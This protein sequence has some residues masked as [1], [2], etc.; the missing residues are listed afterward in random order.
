MIPYKTHYL[1]TVGRGSA[2]IRAPLVPEGIELVGV[3][4]D[5]RYKVASR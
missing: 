3:E 5:S 2:T 1:L 4:V